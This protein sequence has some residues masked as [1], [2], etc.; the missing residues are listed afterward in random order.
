MPFFEY[1]I[2]SK[3]IFKKSQMTKENFNRLGKQGWEL[4]QIATQEDGIAKAIFKRA[5]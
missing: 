2:I 1:K 3:K 5:L 4:I